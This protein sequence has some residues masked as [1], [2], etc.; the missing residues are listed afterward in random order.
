MTPGGEISQRTL[1]E[2]M[3]TM[4]NCFSIANFGLGI[5]E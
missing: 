5:N 3:E 1:R 4:I 2:D